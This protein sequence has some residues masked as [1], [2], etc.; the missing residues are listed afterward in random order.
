VNVEL[1]ASPPDTM[2]G[3]AS[4]LTD[5]SAPGDI[6]FHAKWDNFGPLFARNRSNLYLGGMDPIFQ[7]VHDPKMYWEFFYLSADLNTEW[8]CD[9]FPC[10]SGVATDTHVALRDHFRARWVVVEPRRNPRFT[11]YLFN[12]P[13][14]RLVHETQREAVFEVLPSE[15]VPSA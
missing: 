15:A 9:A 8:T 6:V 14:Y 1:V 11:L 13:R 5:N 12:D 3:V 7:F 10:A 2:A 4:F